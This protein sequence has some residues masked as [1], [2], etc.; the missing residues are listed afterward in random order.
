MM[1]MIMAIA[2]SSYSAYRIVLEIPGLNL[3][4]YRVTGQR[5]NS[6]SS[7]PRS[8][9][10]STLPIA[11]LLNT[12][13]NQSYRGHGRDAQRPPSHLALSTSMW[14]GDNPDFSWSDVFLAIERQHAGGNNMYTT[15]LRGDIMAWE[16]EASRRHEQ[17]PVIPFAH[18]R[19]LVTDQSISKVCARMR[20]D[21]ASLREFSVEMHIGSQELVLLRILHR[22]YLQRLAFQDPDLRVMDL[23]SRAEYDV[24]RLTGDII[25]K[26]LLRLGAMR[27]RVLMRRLRRAAGRDPWSARIADLL[28]AAATGST[29]P[30][31]VAAALSLRTKDDARRDLRNGLE[32]LVRRLQDNGDDDG[33]SPPSPLNCRLPVGSVD[34][35][36]A[37]ARLAWE[38][39]R[40]WPGLS[41]IGPVADLGRT[42]LLQQLF[43][44][45]KTY[46]LHSDDEDA[47]AQG[48]GDAF[49]PAG[50]PRDSAGSRVRRRLLLHVA[51]GLLSNAWGAAGAPLSILHDEQPAAAKMREARDML[52]YDDADFQALSLDPS[53]QDEVVRIA[54]GNAGR[55]GPTAPMTSLLLAL[56]VGGVRCG[57]AIAAATLTLTSQLACLSATCALM[58]F[59]IYRVMR[60]PA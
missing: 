28:A 59:A 20:M 50:L 45:L 16:R 24:A 6:A 56:R 48:G 32:R 15:Q 4:I 30:W 41:N 10:S 19:R 29:T 55:R 33:L 5:G 9:S 37:E 58:L 26:H 23:F 8:P 60:T 21:A 13:N 1:L 34:L 38:N 35:L 49:K 46:W 52:G 39:P 2:V 57:L 40:A 47:R 51:G 14:G 53:V 44:A 12:F 43:A 54:Q 3:A 18:H 7:T 36:K 31:L 25:E 17:T 11:H 22:V 42:A 27:P